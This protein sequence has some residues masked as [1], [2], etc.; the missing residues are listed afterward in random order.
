MLWLL[1]EK[2]C[3]APESRIL[4]AVVGMTSHTWF[5]LV[6]GGFEE[7]ADVV[8][9]VEGQSLPAHS[10]FLASQSHFFQNMLKDL[11]NDLRPSQKIIVP[12]SML[13]SF[14]LQDVT[15]FLHQV[16]NCCSKA[17]E[18]GAEA[19]ELYRLAD[20][21]DAPKL[22]KN[23]LDYLMAQIEADLLFKGSTEE[24]GV[25]KWVLFAK[26]YG[27]A[28][29][30]REAI[31]F[32]V[33]GF[34][35]VSSDDRLPDLSLALRMQL[36]TGYSKLGA[37]SKHCQ[38]SPCK[39]EDYHPLRCRYCSAASC[40]GH[41]GHVYSECSSICMVTCGKDPF[42]GTSQEVFDCLG[43]ALC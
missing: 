16:Y 8:L 22:M 25:L 12:A 13:S 37:A 30:E 6:T 28:D 10:Q 18:S 1:T 2:L 15:T 32:I 35:D 21:F 11:S 17:P 3:S 38:S 39:L 31:A 34:A 33:N 14:K 19:H 4:L 41:V 24:D 26:Q 43:E 20:C 9:E 5:E 27:L 29:L 23:C 7:S 36:L 42:Y 40:P